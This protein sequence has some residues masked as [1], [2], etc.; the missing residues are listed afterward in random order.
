MALLWLVIATLFFFGMALLAYQLPFIEAANLNQYTFVVL[1]FTAYGMG[2]LPFIS[3][4]LG[5]RAASRLTRER[6]L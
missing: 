4:V 1:G 2:W 6:R 5:V 3:L